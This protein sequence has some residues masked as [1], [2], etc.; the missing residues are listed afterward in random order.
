MRLSCSWRPLHEYRLR[1]RQ[2]CRNFV[3]LR[4]SGLAEQDVGFG[5]VGYPRLF[6][7][8]G[9]TRSCRASSRASL[10]ANDSRQAF[11]WRAIV[12]L[13]VLDDVIKGCCLPRA[14]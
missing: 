14:P 5:L 8:D 11:R 6:A 9:I 1:F 12:L 4:V 7:I 3:L 10:N 13:Q 2:T